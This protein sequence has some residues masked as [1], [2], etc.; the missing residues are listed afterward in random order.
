LITFH[1][2]EITALKRVVAKLKAKV[3]PIDLDVAYVLT[4]LARHLF[5]ATILLSLRATSSCGTSRQFGLD[6]P[7]SAFKPFLT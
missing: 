1:W 2:L 5:V 4:V 3:L 7:I 6:I